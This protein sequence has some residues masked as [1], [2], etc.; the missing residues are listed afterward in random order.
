MPLARAERRNKLKKLAES[1]G[2][3]SV[4]DLLHHAAYDS[5]VPGIC[6]RAD[7]SYTCDCEPD[8]RTNYCEACGHQSVQSCLVLAELI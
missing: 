6:T 8:A 3:E 4:D 2:H 7:C 1:E 5:V